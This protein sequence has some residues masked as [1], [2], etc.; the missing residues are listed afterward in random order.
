MDIKEGE[1]EQCTKIQ[2]QKLEKQKLKDNFHNQKGSRN[3]AR[4]K[5]VIIC[6]LTFGFIYT[7]HLIKESVIFLYEIHE[8]SP[9]DVIESDIQLVTFC[10]VIF[11]IFLIA[12]IS[13]LMYI[14][15]KSHDLKCTIPSSKEE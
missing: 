8:D 14:W 1:R 10:W 15:L 2:E 13:V 7:F 12:G 9:L 4:Q 5:V 3:E 11:A 6:M